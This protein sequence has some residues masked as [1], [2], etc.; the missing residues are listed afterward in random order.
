MDGMTITIDS[1]KDSKKIIEEKLKALQLN[2]QGFDF[3]KITANF[4]WKGDA[5]AVQKAMRDE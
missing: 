1:K 4:S 3:K 2:M 5:L